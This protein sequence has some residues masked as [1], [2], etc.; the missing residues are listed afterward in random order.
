MRLSR[1]QKISVAVAVIGAAGAISTTATTATLS[2]SGHN[3]NITQTGSNDTACLN[4]SQCTQD[5]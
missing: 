1:K 5:K 3:S 2:S 4:N